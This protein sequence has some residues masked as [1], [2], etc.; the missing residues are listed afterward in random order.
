MSKNFSA[1]R[2]DP[3]PASV[4]TMSRE[5]ERRPRREDA[6]A[7]VRDVAEG[8]GVHERRAALERLDEVRADRVLEQQ[9]HRARG[10]EVAGAHGLRSAPYVEPTM[11]RAESLLEILPARGERD[12]RHD[13]ARRDD[14]EALLAHD[15]VRPAPPRPMIT[16]PQRAIVHVDRARPRDAARIDAERVP[17]LQVIVEHRREQRVRARDGVEVAREVQVDVVHREHLRVAAAS[18]AALHAE[19]RAER[20]LADAER[21][22][23]AD[24]AERLREADRGRRLA[25]AG[26]GRVDRGDEHEPCRARAGCEI[27]SGIFA[28][29]L[30]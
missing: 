29:Y 26:G 8:A 15:A 16:L 10:L 27:S 7:A 11:M 18:G 22:A 19:H 21:D 4:T 20:R 13:L 12:D 5:R 25:F 9:R 1:P 28:L 17:L 23:L 6:V 3:N 30:P 2:S 14:H 24:A